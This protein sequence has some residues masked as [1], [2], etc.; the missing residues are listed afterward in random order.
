MDLLRIYTD[1]AREHTWRAE[2]EIALAPETCEPQDRPALERLVEGAL[3]GGA[4]GAKLCGAGL[5]GVVLALPPP[6]GVEAV[7]AALAR[8][9]AAWVLPWR[10][11]D[12]EEAG[13]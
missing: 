11:S 1:A 12:D 3:A 5:G 4:L 6:G 7:S 9:G 8:S 10:V 13:T 2:D